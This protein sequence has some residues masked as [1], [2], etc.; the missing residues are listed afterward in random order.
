MSE[1]KQELTQQYYARNQAAISELS[2]R[3]E[4]LRSGPA[5]PEAIEKVA[6]EIAKLRKEFSDA[7]TFLPSY[8]QRQVDKQLKD[9]E[10]QLESLRTAAAPK[11]KFAFKRKAAKAAPTTSPPATEPTQTIPPAVPP[12]ADVQST[13]PTSGLSISGHSNSY[14]TLS[15]LSIPWSSASDLTI[16]DLDNCIVNFLPSPDADV[17]FTALHARNLSNTVLVLPI[18]TGSALLHDM[19][20]CVIALG[21]RQFRMHT[22]SDVDVYISIASN[23]IIE[24]CSGIRFADYPA[25]LRRSPA[26]TASS[27]SNSNYLAVQDFSHIRATPSPN[28]SALPAEAAIRDDQWPLNSAVDDVLSTLAELLPVRG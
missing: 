9:L 28:W 13:A 1:T 25:S 8:D 17:T 2:S 11:T 14:L 7:I 27:K 23:P 5:T 12:P 22:S 3:L 21:S 26:D 20:N 6:F 16:S 24:H 15:S 4:S 18:I 10:G 19:K